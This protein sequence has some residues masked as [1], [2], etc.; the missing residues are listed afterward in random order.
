M[1]TRKDLGK[2]GG[3]A[4]RKSFHTNDLRRLPGANSVPKKLGLFFRKDWIPLDNSA[5]IY[6]NGRHNT[7]EKNERKTITRK[8]EAP[9]IYQHGGTTTMVGSA[10][11]D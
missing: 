8:N 5:D 6:Y 4:E 2:P 7:K 9:N 10:R 11:T 3:A 1:L